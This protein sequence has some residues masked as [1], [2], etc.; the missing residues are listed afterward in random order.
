MDS[1]L[2]NLWINENQGGSEAVALVSYPGDLSKG[3][4]RY[5]DPISGFYVSMKVSIWEEFVEKNA[6]VVYLSRYQKDLMKTKAE[7]KL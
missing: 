2:Y 7:A 5:H 3:Y 6:V 4:G 1:F